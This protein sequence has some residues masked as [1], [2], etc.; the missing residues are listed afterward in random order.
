[1]FAASGN[2]YLQKILKAKIHEEEI[3]NPELSVENQEKHILEAAEC[4]YNL[5]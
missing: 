1:M 2:L 5:A 3:S 4:Y